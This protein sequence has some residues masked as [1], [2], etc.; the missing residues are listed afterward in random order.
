MFEKLGILD[1]MK[2]KSR[3]IP[4]DPVAGVVARGDAELGFQQI[5]EL[6]PAPGVDLVGPLPPEVQKI[7][8]FSAGI[9]AGAKEPEAGRALIRFLTSAAAAPV[10]EKSGL[11][12]MVA[13]AK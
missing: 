11:E 10:I 4:A 2:P 7:T 12:P 8:I 3:M 6:L 13:G 1:H 5:S 9:V